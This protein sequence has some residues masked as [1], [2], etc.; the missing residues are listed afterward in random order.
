[1]EYHEDLKQT[2]SRNANL[3]LSISRWPRLCI[4]VFFLVLG[5][6]G[7]ANAQYFG[8]NKVQYEDYNYKVLHTDHFDFYIYPREYPAIYDFAQLSE[9][10]Y[11]RY[12]NLF[13][14]A[15]K[16]PN[17]MIIYAN[18]ADFQQTNLT[19][20]QVGVG[21]GGFTEGLRNRVVLPFAESNA[22]TNHVLGHELVHAFQYDIARSAGKG[23]FRAMN[24]MPLW[25]I[26]GMSEYLSLGPGGTHTSMWLRDAVLHNDVPTIK[27]ISKNRKYFPYRYG[28]SIWSFIGTTWGDEAVADLFRSSLQLGL[29][30]GMKKTLGISLDSL[31]AAWRQSVKDRY[32]NLVVR[33]KRPENVGKK[34][35]APDIDAGSRNLS[36]S[37]S[38]DGKYVAFISSKD[39]FSLD[40]FIADAHSGK[41]IR[42]LTRTRT[43]AH[44][45]ALRFI[46]SSGTWGPDSKR[47]A[48]TIFSRGDNRIRIV[49]VN[50]GDLTK[51]LHFDKIGSITNPAW[52]PNGRY[53]AFAG[54]HGGYSDLY[55]Y[56]MQKDSL[57]QLTNDKY[58]NLQPTWSPDGS[59]LAFIT[60][61]GTGTDFDALT[62]GPMRLAIMDMQSHDVE[63]LHRFYDSKQINPQFSPDGQSIYFVSD[64]LGVNN[65]FRYDR[66]NREFY[67]VTNVATGI[68]GISESSP[69]ITVSR[70]EGSMVA[71]VFQ[72]TNY[73]G[74]RIPKKK[75]KGE[76]VNEQLASNAPESGKQQ[77]G[78][79][80]FVSDY[81]R[82]P[83]PKFPPKNNFKTTDY[84]PKLTLDYLGGGGGIGI[85][86]SQFGGGV[87]GGINA[88]FSD[89]LN[90]HKV[91][92]S[93]RAQ[94]RLKDISGSVGYLNQDHRMIWGGALSHYSFRTTRASSRLD[95]ISVG[96]NRVLAQ[97]LLQFNRRLFE[98][99]ASAITKYPFSP[100]LR[101][102]GNLGYTRISYDYEVTKY[103][104]AGGQVLDRSRENVNAPSPLNLAST[105]I[106]LV[107][108]NS[109]SAFTGPIMGHRF[110]LEVEPTV[111]SLDF[112][113]VLADYRR[114]FYLRPYTLAFRFIQQGR[115]GAQAEN[116]RMSPNFLG[117]ES[118]IRG[119]NPQSFDPG[120]CTITPN[121]ECAE[122]SR[123]LGSRIAVMNAEFRVPFTG[124]KEL[125]LIKSRVIPSTLSV[126]LD[127]GVAWTSNEPPVWKLKKKSSERIP[128]FSSGVS[129]RVNLFGY[130]VGELYYAVPFQRP[131]K[132]GYLGFQISPG[133]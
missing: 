56:D 132:S 6:Q 2:G 21:T 96:G 19:Q 74:Y 88:R 128:V 62:Y 66:Q 92:A 22:S 85:S 14:H 86:T 83:R 53:I 57:T 133:W 48:F 108:D 68:S 50:S 80:S 20:S 72:K 52:S 95:T 42:K 60:D 67:R 1:M 12:S 54:S 117:H 35:L 82:S 15:F 112:V 123:L 102:E 126:F 65:I 118:L 90:Q 7:T 125:S 45:N 111:G 89:I 30:G 3:N 97:Q 100:T 38:P 70:D 116:N 44:L 122:F 64:Y 121:G 17:P 18:H 81:L 98:E 40:L 101:L 16:K 129:L 51:E 33:G 46:Q 25:Y 23:S 29:N 99:R 34:L 103:T 61:Q 24:Q 5:L 78:S 55:L 27:Q 36:P 113:K 130:L 104:V 32:D 87:A 107:G 11:M 26:E 120:E 10:W 9:R 119:Y 106:A 124:V 114:Y 47:F 13:H 4:L 41:V 31:S 58:S 131:G 109:L 37:L 105:S 73:I 127:G 94:G 110:R 71:T 49:D 28:H 39:L 43:D 93:V 63:L 75:M 77:L 8:R 91:I 76:L 69:A 59:E 115:Y 79:S 84:D